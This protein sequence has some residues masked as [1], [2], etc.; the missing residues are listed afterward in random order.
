M[1]PKLLL[2]LL[3]L[4]NAARV[5]AQ[6]N[7]WTEFLLRNHCKPFFQITQF[8]YNFYNK[9]TGF[10]KV[11]ISDTVTNIQFLTS[12]WTIST[13][14]EIPASQPDKLILTF[15]CKLS[16]VSL[17]SS[18]LSFGL[19][20]DRWSASN[21]VLMPGAAY[22][23]NRFES[24]RIKYSPKLLDPKDI[25]PSMPMIVSDVP[26]LNITA[27][28]S[29][30]Q[31]RSGA[32]TIPSIGFQSPE[33][34]TG[35]FMVSNQRS[36]LGDHG[37]TIEE[38]RDRKQALISIN[39]PVVRENNQYFITDNQVSSMDKA[40]DFKTG[41][42]ITFSVTLYFFEAPGI[43]SLFETY[44]NIR[45]EQYPPKKQ[46]PAIPFSACF[47]VQEQKY[48]TEN[49]VEQHGYYSVGMRENFLQDW[50]IGWTGGMINT[51]PLLFAGNSSTQQRV[52]RNFD[53]LF[54]NGICPAGFFWD[55]GEKGTCWYGG[56]IRKP[57][58]KNWHLIRK[59]GDGLYYILKQFMLM[60]KKN[61]VVKDEWKKGSEQVADAFVTLWKKW[62]QFGQFVD[63]ETGDVVVGGSTSG[64]IVPASLVL[65][66]KYF[67]NSNYLAVAESSADSMYLNYVKKG[68]TC[69]GPGDAMQNPD[70]ESAYA[71]L[72]S[73][74][75]LYE[76]TR[77]PLWLERSIEMANQFI[78]WEMPYNYVF[79]ENS[80]LAK[81][82]VKTTGVVS[83][84]TQNKHG[85]PGICTYSGIALWRLYRATDDT[86]YMEWLR[87]IAFTM[88]QYLSH[89]LNPIDNMK[90]G[91]MSER[92]S[93]TDWLEGIG[94]LM[95]GSTWAEISLMLSYIELP[96]VYIRP[97]KSYIC[98]MDNIEG[99]ITRDRKSF[100]EIKLTNPTRTAAKV[101]VYS[102][103]A[104]DCSK[105][106]QENILLD[107]PVVT[108]NAGESRILRF[109]K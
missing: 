100:I 84:N 42:E 53:W 3:L 34:K 28:P 6:N 108:L 25:G 2:F 90:S 75:L 91:W 45:M 66:Y 14:A 11:C 27:G 10:E 17:T 58:T 5:P 46:V 86:R 31:E 95:Y 30:I 24:R 48:N 51:Y 76:V 65:A 71:M 56:D 20:M 59:S 79:P 9:V 43:T 22:N 18:N 44:A 50:Q 97:D 29:K 96:G 57:H 23:G 16:S 32:M 80:T 64:A 52:I 106:L 62:G 38:S 13:H 81:L 26:R 98:V 73:F 83:A 109:K 60:E 77:K 102:E 85:A 68:I 63:S 74:T 69:G 49:W 93:T 104:G 107:C 7:H 82:G 8:D 35:F 39:V 1:K 89:P 15:R 92:V 72:E 103:S 99:T 67:N 61:I 55:S 47:E 88:P 87:E 101:K 12:S 33:T 70:S 36:V 78:T 54:P 4:I 105:S 19:E 37:F 40:P 94:E 21:Y 41:D